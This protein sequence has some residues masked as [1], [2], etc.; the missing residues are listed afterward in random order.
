M[1]VDSGSGS[2]YIGDYLDFDLEIREGESRRYAMAVRSPAG[3]AQEEM[4]F[5][6]D[7]RQLT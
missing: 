4:S 1:A 6:F 5:P 3:E 7:E 2:G